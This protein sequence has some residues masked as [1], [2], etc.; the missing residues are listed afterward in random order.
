MSGSTTRLLTMTGPMGNDALPIN[1]RVIEAISEPFSISLSVV[2]PTSSFDPDSILFQPISV[3][4]QFRQPT[5]LPARYFH[6]IA[7]SFTA[8]GPIGTERWGYDL[9]L[10]PA[11]WFLRQTAD[12][13]IWQGKTAVDVI[14]A[15]FADQNLTAVQWNVSPDPPVRETITQ[16][17]ETDLDFVTRLLEEEGCYYFHTHAAGAHTLVIGNDNVS[18][19]SLQKCDDM[20]AA[21]GGGYRSISGWRRTDRT[22][23]G[24][25]QVLDYDPLVP[26]TPVKGDVTTTLMSGGKTSRD[27]FEW[28]ALTAKADIATS[29]ARLRVEAAEATAMLADAAGVNPMFSA[30][31]KFALKQSRDASAESYVLRSVTHLASDATM[32]RSGPDLISYTN[33]FS[34]FP[35][36]TKWRPRITVPRPRMVGVHTALVIGPD[37]QEIYTDKYGRIQIRFF[38][39]HRQ[40]AVAK[41]D[42]CWVRV[43]QP[44]AGSETGTNWGMQHCPR[45]GTEVAVSFMDGDPDRPVVIGSFYNG[46]SMPIFDLS[47]RDNWT[48]SGFRSRSATSAAR[49]GADG[50]SEFSFDDKTGNENVFLHAQKDM[51]TEIEHD[52]TLKVMNCRVV[53]VTKDETVDIGK[54]QTITVGAGR[55]VTI[56]DKDEALT[57]STGNITVTAQQGNITTKASLGNITEQASV[58]NFAIK[59]DA[60]KMT[61]DAMQSITLTCGQNSVK[62]DQMGVTVSGM[63]IKITGQISSELGGLM[64]KV[65]GDAMLTVKGGIVMIN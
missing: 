48:K 35:A 19:P 31:G 20:L 9:E 58:G 62:I 24:K 22:A 28:P 53:N 56:K 33:S 39:D 45:I 65:G 30:G 64:T 46:V 26:N 55:S 6:G 57:V 13:R 23:T 59:V 63:M 37:G 38:W 4:L 1:L 14:K 47:A 5:D 51:L 18:F 16:F 3:S 60:G 43:I 42:I 29:R 25:V 36:A 32:L 61:I 44:W 21:E 17:N 15:V 7:R 52:Q 12:C 2:S 54:A 11:L 10:V 49:G 41:D 8:T 27:V 40:D 50:F 34:A